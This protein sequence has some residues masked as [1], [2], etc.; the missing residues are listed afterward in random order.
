MRYIGINQEG[1]WSLTT[2]ISSLATIV[3]IFNRSAMYSIYAIP[4][5]TRIVSR[6]SAGLDVNRSGAE[7]SFYL[8]LSK[9]C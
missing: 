4:G 8:E 9:L 6:G 7:L 2:G 3:G 1:T 5:Y